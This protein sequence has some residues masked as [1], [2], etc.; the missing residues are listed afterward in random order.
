M[1][2]RNIGQPGT[3]PDLQSVQ[4]KVLHVGEP[5]RMM[6]VMMKMMMIMM[7]TMIMMIMMITMIAMEPRS[8]DFEHLEKWV[9]SPRGKD[10]A[11][12]SRSAP[13]L[14]ISR[15]GS[16]VQGKKTRPSRAAQRRKSRAAPILSI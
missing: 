9:T 7:I 15:D 6:I 10:E 14:S 4:S 5:R 11:L 12:E 3:V 13:I 8:A 2:P 16:F 1:G